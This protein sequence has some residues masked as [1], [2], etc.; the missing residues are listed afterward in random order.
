MVSSCTKAFRFITEGTDSSHYPRHISL[1]GHLGIGLSLFSQRIGDLWEH[2]AHDGVGGELEER[3]GNPGSTEALDQVP[4][5]T[6]FQSHV[7]IEL[8]GEFWRDLESLRTVLEL[9]HV[10]KP[11]LVHVLED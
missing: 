7:H 1:E 2:K 6:D 4:R 5:D 8:L 11:E 10:G 3:I 9:P